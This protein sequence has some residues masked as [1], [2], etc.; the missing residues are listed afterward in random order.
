MGQTVLTSNLQG[1]IA[2]DDADFGLGVGGVAVVDAHIRLVVLVVDDAQEEELS[3]GQQH[4]VGGGVLR[5]CDHRA[6]VAVPRDGGRGVTL[7]LA[8]ERGRLILGHILVLWVLY[9]A[10]VGHLL[11]PCNTHKHTTNITLLAWPKE[12]L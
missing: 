3:A 12:P 5:G 8:V 9:D 10:R 11:N 1:G 4:A 7:G 2:T 6:T